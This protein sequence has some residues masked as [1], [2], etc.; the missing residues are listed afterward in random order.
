VPGGL[1]GLLFD[2]RFGLLTCAPV[3]GAAFTGL[4][5][6]LT[7]REHLRLALELLFV[8]F[9]YLLAVTHFAMWWAGWSAPARFFAPV[10]P[11]FAVPAAI[12]W[13]TM[14]SRVSKMLVSSALVLTA[15]ASA[16][17]VFVDRGRLAFN[18]RE[19]PALW[20]EWLGQ[21]VDLTAATPM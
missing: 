21:P 7:R 3:L 20:L 10:L 4:G 6:M 18:T 16:I 19:A 14:Q 11:L 17:V 13:M 9:P 15:I 1:G 2:Q 12:A 8:V 5:T